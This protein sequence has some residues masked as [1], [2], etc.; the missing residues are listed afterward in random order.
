MDK[1]DF[2]I[3][4]FRR[5]LEM[6]NY[7]G[8][9]INTDPRELA[10]FLDWLASIRI[11]NIRLVQGDHVSKFFDYLKQRRNQRNGNVLSISTLRGYKTT[12]NR[13]AH[14]LRQSQDINLQISV[15]LKEL[16]NK[17]IVVL[18]KDEIEDLYGA[19]EDNLLGIRDRSLLS[20]FYGCGLRRKEGISLKVN[21]VIF[22]GR[23]IRVRKGKGYKERYVPMVKRVIHNLQEYLHYARPALVKRNTIEHLLIG[24]YGNPLKGNAVYERVRL[25]AKRSGIKKKVGIHTL[26][27]SIATHL[28][29]EG[30]KLSEIGRFLGHSSLESTQIYTHV[31]KEI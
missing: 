23:M 14:F 24:Y 28:L 11:D 4:E 12:L 31:Q 13:F 20:I 8:S 9:S 30:M 29:A 6:Q 22:D 17:T 3:R 5:W 15:E 19:T 21:D 16:Y 26:R 10:V 2:Y 25:L 18:T 27:H 1:R 7:A